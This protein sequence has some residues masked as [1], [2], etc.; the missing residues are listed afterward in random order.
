MS[1]LAGLARRS[2]SGV[3]RL[4]ADLPPLELVR[5]LAHEARRQRCQRGRLDGEARSPTGSPDRSNKRERVM[6]TEKRTA[7]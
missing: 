3:V 5:T 2:V 1:H 4:N 7:G 6:P